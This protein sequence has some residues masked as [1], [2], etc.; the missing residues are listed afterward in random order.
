MSITQNDDKYEINLDGRKLKTPNGSLF[1]TRNQWLA[2]MVANEWQS[3]REVIRLSS[4]HLTQLTNTAIDNPTKSC[5]QTIAEDLINFMDSDTLCFRI[6]EPK[7]LSDLQQKQWDPIIQWFQNKF[8][9]QIPV[10]QTVHLSPISKTTKE[11]LYRHLCSHNRWS[12]IGLKFATENLKSLI[13]SLA[14]TQ[15]RI[16]INQSVDFSRLEE[17][18]EIEKWGRLESVHD[19][20]SHALRTRVSAALLFYFT[21]SEMRQLS[22]KGDSS[23]LNLKSSVI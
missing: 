16:S 11:R 20:E 6:N 15:R 3:Q 9:C 23:A 8:D 7:E 10:T 2:L 5:R 1:F 22:Q 21:S 4:M 13:L 12:L 14:L 17:N 18:F 19:L